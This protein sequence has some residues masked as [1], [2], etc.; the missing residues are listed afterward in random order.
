MLGVENVARMLNCDNRSPP[1]TKASNEPDSLLPRNKR[2]DTDSGESPHTRGS[3]TTTRGCMATG[4]EDATVNPQKGT[5]EKAT[6]EA[7]KGVSSEP[8]KANHGPSTTH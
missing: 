2:G 4:E 7:H 1:I 3:R 6:V 8:P 5:F